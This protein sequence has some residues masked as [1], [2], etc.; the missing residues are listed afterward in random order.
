MS[1]SSLEQASLNKIENRILYM[2]KLGLFGTLK[3]FY[4][5][6]QYLFNEAVP[7]RTF[8]KIFMKLIKSKV[9]INYDNLKH[10][11]IYNS[12][13]LFGNSVEFTFPIDLK[14]SPIQ[15]VR[16]RMI[17]FLK[18]HKVQEELLYDIIIASTEAVEN[19]VKYSSHDEIYIKY[20]I[21]N[22]TF[23]VEIRNHYE[24]PE[25]QKDIKRGKYD[26]SLTLMRGM[27]VM[28]KLFD[29]ID[30][31]RIEDKKI[32]IFRASKKLK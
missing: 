30:F 8:L 25:I 9:F 1:L 6:Y 10:E 16:S 21:E 27:L 18:S 11:Y 13:I 4:C 24:I 15:F 28:S 12:E 29:E 26:S 2:G 23:Y 20:Y 19:A 17:S 5:W 32:A 31:D 14:C 7:M 22:K 3:E